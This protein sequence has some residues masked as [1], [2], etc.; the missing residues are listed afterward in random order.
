MLT[1]SDLSGYQRQLGI[2][3]DASRKWRISTKE[4]EKDFLDVS[5]GVSLNF[6]MSTRVSR[7]GSVQ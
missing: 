6:S 4:R 5:S 2:A 7:F 3:M 1:C